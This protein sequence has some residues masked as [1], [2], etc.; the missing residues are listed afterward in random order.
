MLKV[1]NTAIGYMP[2]MWFGSRPLQH[3]G[4]LTLRSS[5][6]IPFFT[7]PN[8]KSVLCLSESLVK[9]LCLVFL[10]LY[11]VRLQLI[12]LHLLGAHRLYNQF[13]CFARLL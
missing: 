10:L 4:K 13:I 8:D 12:G 1:E 5:S 3:K 2:C 7:S 11:I 9:R 6:H